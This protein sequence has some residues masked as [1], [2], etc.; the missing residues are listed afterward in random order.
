MARSHVEF[1]QSQVLPFSNGLY[2]GARP[3]VEMRILS[4]DHEAW[5]CIDHVALACRMVPRRTGAFGL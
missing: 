2:G 5:R 4:M 3:D 1:I